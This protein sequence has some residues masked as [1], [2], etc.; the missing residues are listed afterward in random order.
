MRHLARVQPRYARIA[1]DLVRQIESGRYRVGELLPSEAEICSGY[2][3]SHHTARSAIAI[4]QNMRLVRPEQGRGSRVISNAISGRFVHVLDSIPE[5]GALADEARITVRKRELVDPAG[6]KHVHLP[7][8]ERWHR[9]EAIR[10]MRKEEPLVWKEIYLPE[11]F[12]EVARIV[13]KRHAPIYTLIEEFF[14]VRPVRVQQEISA[15]LIDGYVAAELRVA[16]LSAGLVLDR[17]Y[18]SADAQLIQLARGIYRA[19]KFRYSSDLRLEI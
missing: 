15:T 6:V 13:G 7:G 14:R 18:Y 1:E 17:R 12:G 19:D 9:I 11:R 10:Y 3:V 8:I 16:Q 5:F 2:K 4:L